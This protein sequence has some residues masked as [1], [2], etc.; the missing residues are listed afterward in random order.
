MAPQLC[1]RSTARKLPQRKSGLHQRNPLQGEVEVAL[2][3]VLPV[4][5]PAEAGAEAAAVA[6]ERHPQHLQ[7]EVNKAT[8]ET[9]GTD[10]LC[11]A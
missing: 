9:S 11:S 2:E 8:W 3:A 6:V 10:L 5:L 7:V 4:V 1:F